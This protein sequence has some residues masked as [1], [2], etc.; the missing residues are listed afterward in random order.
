MGI[1]AFASDECFFWHD[2]GNEALFLT[3][4][5]SI[6]SDGD[7]DELALVGQGTYGITLLSAGGVITVVETA[8][9]GECEDAYSLSSPPR[10]LA[11]ADIGMGFVYLIIG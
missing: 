7:A 4:G 1:N 5:G 8:G 9:N 3:S 10:R 2:T 6:Q 11:E